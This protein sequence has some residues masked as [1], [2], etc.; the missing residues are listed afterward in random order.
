PIGNCRPSTKELVEAFE[1]APGRQA[2]AAVGDA[3]ECLFASVLRR[4]F[5][6]ATLRCI[7]DG[8]LE[9]IDQHLFDEIG[10]HPEQWK[11]AGNLDVNFATLNLAP[12]PSQ[13]HADEFL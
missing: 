6:A 3:Y 13:R 5:N 7:A 12:E 11:V 10:G 9:K 2:G 4:D 1:L 8:V